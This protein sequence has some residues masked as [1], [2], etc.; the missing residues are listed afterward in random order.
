MLMSYDSLVAPSNEQRGLYG[1]G[2]IS[3][4]WGSESLGRDA[5]AS[6]EAL[7]GVI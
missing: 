2:A 1:E 6:R 3:P 7:G 4:G 5:T